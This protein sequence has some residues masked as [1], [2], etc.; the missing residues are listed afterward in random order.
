MKAHSLEIDFAHLCIPAPKGGK[1]WI[2]QFASSN[3]EQRQQ[4]KPKMKKK[5]KNEK[6]KAATSNECITHHKIALNDGLN[7]WS[8]NLRFKQ[9]FNI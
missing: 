3:I 1:I 9:L 8:W 4:K 7:V 5:P 6:Q 2:Q